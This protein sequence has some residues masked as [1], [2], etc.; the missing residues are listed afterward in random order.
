MSKH[1][2]RSELR[3]LI[4]MAVFIGAILWSLPSDE[5]ELSPAQCHT[6]YEAGEAEY[7][8]DF[9]FDEDWDFA[10]RICNNHETALL[11]A[12]HF[13]KNTR[14][15]LPD[16]EAEFDFYEWAKAIKPIFRKRDMLAYSGIANFAENSV[17]IS[18]FKLEENDVISIANII[19]H[20]LRHLEE[21]FDTHTSCTEI[22]NATCDVK[23]EDNPFEG[24]AYNYNVAYLYH[25]IEYGE[26]TRTQR[27]SAQRLLSLILE[28]RINLIQPQLREKYEKAL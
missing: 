10:A 3:F 12:L 22:A 20:E 11:N 6:L 14:F 26:I 1:H 28:E 27:F 17:D 18:Y 23:L 13:L 21:G 5:R 9:L 8:K 2:N 25:L 4:L 24:G 7:L 15:L 16:S 19:V